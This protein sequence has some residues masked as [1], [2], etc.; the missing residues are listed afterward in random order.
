VRVGLNLVFLSRQ[1]GG[2]GRYAT[3]LLPALL[4]ADPELELV[5]FH[6]SLLPPQLRDVPGADRIEWVDLRAAPSE[7]RN[8]VV[9]LAALPL[10]A[11]RR[12]CQLVHSPA[13]V[14][15]LA[16]VPTVVTITDL[17]WLH[18]P[19]RWESRG[20]A[21]KIRALAV[22]NARRARRVLAISEATR[23][24]LVRTLG[25]PE[26]KI[27]VTPLGVGRPL[28]ASPEDVHAVRSRLGVGE[29]PIVLCIAQK[30]P[31]KN[32]EVIVR[33]LPDLGEEPVAVLPGAPTA[34]ERKLRTLAESVGVAER[35][36]LPEYVSERELEALY[37]AA[38]CV[39]LPSLIEG[40]GLPVLE[41]MARGLPVA[42]SDR[43]SLPEVAGDAALLF[44]PLDQAAVTASL[45]RLLVDEELRR[46]LSRRGR[47][48]AGLFTWERT[49]RLTLA[50]YARALE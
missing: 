29:R 44:D 22:S 31:Y 50:S 8:L 10:L 15:P 40:F 28:A 11:R 14:G 4:A 38:T 26:E 5:A 23:D 45:R 42:C 20:V 39:V 3:E 41:A 48:R 9:Q 24:D 35:V 1:G 13:N 27:D 25:L 21:R 36:L 37:G 49:A 2:I 33:A 47:E 6:G 19:E 16:G 43:P 17:I 46:E 30:R 12:G 32:Q 18:E 7:R 34:Y